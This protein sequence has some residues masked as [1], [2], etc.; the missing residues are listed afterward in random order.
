MSWL[1]LARL[2][3][4]GDCYPAPIPRA[5]AEALAF[6]PSASTVRLMALGS[7]ER[8]FARSSNAFDAYSE[9]ND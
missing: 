5:E 3:S 8:R 9:E 4:S 7:I 6:G 2:T 1:H